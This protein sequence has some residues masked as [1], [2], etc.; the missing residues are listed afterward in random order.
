MTLKNLSKIILLHF[1]PNICILYIFFQIHSFKKPY[2]KNKF[3]KLTNF[4][5]SLEAGTT[6]MPVLGN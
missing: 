2:I 1:D 6:D 5:K 3:Q 4:E